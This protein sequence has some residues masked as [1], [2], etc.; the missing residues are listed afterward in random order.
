MF[1]GGIGLLSDDAFAFL[2]GYYLSGGDSI[3]LLG[4]AVEPPDRD[5]GRIRFAEAKVQPKVALRDVG[6][7]ATDFIHLLLSI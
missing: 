6:S 3:E 1:A 4:L 7:A 2:D 5:I